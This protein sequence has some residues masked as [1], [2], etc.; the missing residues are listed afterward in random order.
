MIKN[1]DLTI[2]PCQG[3]IRSV[4]INPYIDLYI[5]DRLSRSIGDVNRYP[6]GHLSI[7]LYRAVH[8]SVS[9]SIHVQVNVEIDLSSL[10][11]VHID[12][13]T[14]RQS[15]IEIDLYVNIAICYIDRSLHRAMHRSI[16][17]LINLDIELSTQIE[18]EIDQCSDQ[19][20]SIRSI[21]TS[22]II[23]TL[24]NIRNETIHINIVTMEF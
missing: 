9:R 1:I 4:Y 18:T 17:R 15:I 2:V 21:P 19:P 7:D 13:Y 20:K 11:C 16:S 14:D 6:Y 22:S 24:C 10:I 3:Q 5:T 8:R 23:I 12:L